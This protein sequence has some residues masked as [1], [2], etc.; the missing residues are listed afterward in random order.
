MKKFVALL[1]AVLAMMLGVFVTPAH[2]TIETTCK[3][4]IQ[5]VLTDWPDTSSSGIWAKD[6]VTRKMVICA[7]KKP[8]EGSWTYLSTMSDSGSTFITTGP[9]SPRTSVSLAAGISGQMS[10]GMIQTFMA[11]KDFAG[12]DAAKSYLETT[13]FDGVS[14][15]SGAMLGAAY[16]GTEGF[17]LK[18]ATYK[19]EYKTACETFTDNDG[20]LSGDITK[21]CPA[22]SNSPS[23]SPSTSATPSTSI[24]TSTSASAVPSLPVT[25]DTPTKLILLI[26][27]GVGAVATGV[28]LV[29]ISRH[30]RRE[31]QA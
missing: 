16:V 12:F 15:R 21:T 9:K 25:G 31:F 22:A 6:K 5:F 18:D 13:T 19:W 4:V 1:G 28:G 29:G 2:A 3:T 23:A 14:V 20:K 27:F 8:S 10:G 17:N 26:V 11:P 30:R 24:S 7:I